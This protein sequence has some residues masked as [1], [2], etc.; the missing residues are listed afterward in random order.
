MALLTAAQQNASKSRDNASGKKKMTFA[1]SQRLAK[2]KAYEK[3]S[4][5]AKI[6]TEN[7]AVFTE[8]IA[9]M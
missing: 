7:L 9:R 3:K 6:K 8:Q 5:R 1:E 2:L 4:K